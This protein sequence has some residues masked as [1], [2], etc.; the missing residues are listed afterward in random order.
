MKY[1]KKVN[2]IGEIQHLVAAE[3]LNEDNFIEISAEEYN[4]LLNKNDFDDMGG[5]ALPSLD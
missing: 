4:Y 2:G 5:C 3:F 1:Y